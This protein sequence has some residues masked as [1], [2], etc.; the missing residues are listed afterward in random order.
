[1]CRVPAAAALLLALAACR[2]DRV[3]RVLPPDVIVDTYVQQSASKVDVLWIVDNSESMAGEQENLARNF[4]SFIE[5]F[6]RGAVDYRIA[7]TTT[8]IF[9]DA[10]RFKGSPKILSPQTGNVIAAFQNNIR[11][12]TSGSPF[13]AG[14]DAAEM[15]LVRQNEANATRLQQIDGCKR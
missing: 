9:A 14:L 6:V 1:M 5:L 13:E 2:D 15:A 12:G 8:D 10:G 11:V 7:V 3:R 4:Q